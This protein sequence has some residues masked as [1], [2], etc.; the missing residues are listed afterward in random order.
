MGKRAVTKVGPGH[1]RVDF[2]KLKAKGVSGLVSGLTQPEPAEVDPYLVG[3]AIRAVMRGCKFKTVHNHRLVWNEYKVFLSVS[4]YQTLLPLLRRLKAGLDTAI[5]STLSELKAETVG[6]VMVRILVDEEGEAPGNRRRHRRLRRQREAG[7][8]NRR[9]AH[10]PGAADPADRGRGGHD[11]TGSGARGGRSAASRLGSR[12]GI[13][14][15]ASQ[16][17]GRPAAP[18]RP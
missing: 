9:R 12:P 13:H 4:D 11:R 1:F 5:R 3:R 10:G 6:D 18:G 8:G 2:T 16:G 14:R 7:S 15:A 17:Q